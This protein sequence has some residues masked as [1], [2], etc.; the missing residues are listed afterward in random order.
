MAALRCRDDA[1]SASSLAVHRDPYLSRQPTDCARAMLVYYKI[2]PI[3]TLRTEATAV[4]FVG[5]ARTRRDELIQMSRMFLR[6]VRARQSSARV[7][8][9]NCVNYIQSTKIYITIICVR[10]LQTTLVA[11]VRVNTTTTTTTANAHLQ[12]LLACDECNV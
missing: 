7:R 11:A 4:V 9:Q 6:G 1:A 12:L 5:V 8:W 10:A 2:N 3:T